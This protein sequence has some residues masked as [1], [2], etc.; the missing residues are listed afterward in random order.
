MSQNNKRLL[1][2]QQFFT[3]TYSVISPQVYI[4]YVITNSIS[5]NSQELFYVLL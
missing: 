5:V 1:T 4:R 3:L 2:E